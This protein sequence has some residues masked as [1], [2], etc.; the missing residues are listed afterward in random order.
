MSERYQ[1]SARIL[2]SLALLYLLFF[3]AALVLV[4]GEAYAPGV[5]FVILYLISSVVLTGALA[6]LVL[7]GEQFSELF[8]TVV[9]L[10]C[11]VLIA[12]VIFFTGA[13]SS[14][15]YVLYFP[16]LVAPALDAGV[17]RR[18]GLAVVA[19]VFV[20]YTLA[21]LPDVL[22]G[23]AGDGTSGTVLFRLSAF[24][25]AGIFGL[26][27]G[28]GK[29]SGRA[30]PEEAGSEDV[31]NLDGK[32]SQLLELVSGEV[33]A[34]PRVPVG[35]VLVDPGSGIEDMEAL[36]ERVRVRIGEPVPV[37]EEKVFGVVLSGADE[38][39]AEGAARRALVAAS[40]QGAG[41]FSAG[42][43]IY[44]QDA[45][46]PEGLLGAAARALE[47][48]RDKDSTSAV[49]LAGKSAAGDQGHRATR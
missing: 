36:L 15:L 43:A 18:A 27:A 5:S 16:L 10:S 42:A 45:S 21:V 28:S 14:E 41:D 37:G 12:P 32:G 23:F 26:F 40:S 35:V 48:A 49:V 8:C 31:G 46:S 3:G 24:V 39:R 22:G 44:P 4:H 9:Y 25:L 20:G 13:A 1:G 38:R 2:K 11:A 29:S 30:A 17:S 6:L 19:A 7:P 47:T 34:R 33:S